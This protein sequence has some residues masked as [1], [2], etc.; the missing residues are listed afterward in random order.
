ML[1]ADAIGR[2][3]EVEEKLILDE[4]GKVTRYHRK[5]AIRR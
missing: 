1:S 4:F 5:H 3:I 2:R